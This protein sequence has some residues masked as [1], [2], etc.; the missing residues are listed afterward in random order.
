VRI[1]IDLTAVWRPATGMEHVAIEMTK[2]LLEVDREN[3]Y[4]LFFSQEIHPGFLASIGRFEAVRVPRFHEVLTKNMFLP[5][6]AAEEKLDYMHYPV[7]PPPWHSHCPT[8]WTLPDA[9]PWLYPE[10]MKLKSR[11]YYKILGGRAIDTSRVLITD[12]QASQQDLVSALRIQRERIHVIYPGLRSGFRQHHNAAE[13]ERVRQVHNLPESFVLFVG[14]LEPRKNL[15]RI[16][17]A[18]RLLKKRHEFEPDLVIVGRKGWLYHPIFA[19]LSSEGLAGHVHITGYVSE[20][21]LLALY[22][23]ARLLVFPSLYEGFGLP[24]IEAM[25]CGCPVVTSDRGAL[26]E[27]TDNCAIHCDPENA[28][29]IAH[30]LWLAHTDESLRQRLIA[31]GLRR[32]MS[33]SWQRYAHQF[34]DIL[35]HSLAQESGELCSTS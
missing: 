28:T 13:F 35:G 16:L 19:Q 7:F 22:N 26:R 15:S 23:M 20:D 12:T 6:L 25:A 10:T 24:S 18:F 9:T 11:W 2:A 29:A 32:A 30:A 27:V 21:D 34:L 8:G 5:R 33:F 31:S 14:T 4:V 1:G 17:E 3:E